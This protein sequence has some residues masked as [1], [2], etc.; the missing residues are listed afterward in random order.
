[1]NRE[2]E[3]DSLA[4]TCRDEAATVG[5]S[6][7]DHLAYRIR[8]QVE[9]LVQRRLPIVPLVKS[10]NAWATSPLHEIVHTRPGLSSAWK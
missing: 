4:R 8:L 10:S 9:N 6:G 2:N 7:M 5:I 3:H 1:V